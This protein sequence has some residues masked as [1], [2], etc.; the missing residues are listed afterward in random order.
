MCGVA[1]APGTTRR[2]AL[3]RIAARTPTRLYNDRLPPQ[4]TEHPA[5]TLLELDLRL[6]VE[7]LPRTCDVGPTLLRSVDRQRLEDDLALRTG[8]AEHRVREFEQ[9]ELVRVADIHRQVLVTLRERNEPADHVV[10]V[11]EA[12]GLGPVPEHSQRR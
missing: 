2:A 12:P 5:E 7:N 3:A 11:T 4:R 9:R 8:D 6:P 1:P 10:D